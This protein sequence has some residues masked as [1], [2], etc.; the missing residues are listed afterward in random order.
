MPPKLIWEPALLLSESPVEEGP[1]D[2]PG[3]A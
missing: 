2:A 3:V 1:G